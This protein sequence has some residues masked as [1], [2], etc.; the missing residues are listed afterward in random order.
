MAR[1]SE[2]R[3]M[4]A[5]ENMIVAVRRSDGGAG[6]YLVHAGGFAEADSDFVRNY[7][8]GWREMTPEEVAER[9]SRRRRPADA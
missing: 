9:R 8:A 2:K 5:T 7:P 4:V 1:R 6:E 3:F